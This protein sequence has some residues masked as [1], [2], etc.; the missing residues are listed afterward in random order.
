VDKVSIEAK[1][2]SYE[3]LKSNYAKLQDEIMSLSDIKKLISQDEQITKTKLAQNIIKKGVIN[4]ILLS[5]LILLYLVD[6][7]IAHKFIYMYFF[8]CRN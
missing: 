8:D 3:D 2:K 4:K 1:V 7:R 5:L 6:R